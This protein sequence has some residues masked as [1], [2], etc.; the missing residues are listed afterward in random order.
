MFH[1]EKPSWMRRSIAHNTLNII[2]SNEISLN[3]QV[4]PRPRTTMNDINSMYVLVTRH[5]I[6][7]FFSPLSNKKNS[8]SKR[9]NERIIRRKDPKSA[10]GKN[11]RNKT[12]LLKIVGWRQG[13]IAP[14]SEK[15]QPGK[16]SW[17]HGQKQ[18]LVC[19]KNEK[20]KASRNKCARRALDLGSF[21]YACRMRK[22]FNRGGVIGSYAL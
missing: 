6:I 16:E 20:Q 3:F 8:Y 2:I 15:N 1:S 5:V 14:M 9:N 17:E 21:L 13:L 4:L 12:K 19:R 11:N 22:N 7:F 10:K 18:N